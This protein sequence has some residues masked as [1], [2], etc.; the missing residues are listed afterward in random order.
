MVEFAKITAVAMEVDPIRGSL[1]VAL[2]SLFRQH[3]LGR[4]ELPDR[5]LALCGVLAAAEPQVRLGVT[6]GSL[7]V[8]HL[9]ET[10]RETF[11]LVGGGTATLGTWGRDAATL[12]L[13]HGVPA[14][15]PQAL[16]AWTDDC[17]ERAVIAVWLVV[18]AAFGLIRRRMRWPEN[19]LS[20]EADFLAAAIQLAEAEAR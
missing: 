10:N 3:R 12:L 11:A 20:R 5:V 18:E 15:W 1:R 6:H 16:D 13:S 9:V 2:D 14:W 8:D 17:S 19:A 7:T 4:V